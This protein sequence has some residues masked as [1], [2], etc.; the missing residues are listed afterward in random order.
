MAMILSPASD[1]LSK[2]VKWQTSK[3]FTYC[4]LV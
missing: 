4:C 3:W 1:D 2:F